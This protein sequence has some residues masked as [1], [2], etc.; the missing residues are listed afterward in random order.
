MTAAPPV[1]VVV[2]TRDRPAMLRAAVSAALA[3]EYP[4]AVEV[5]VVHDQS[6]PDTGL[7]GGDGHRRVRVVANTRTPGL[8]GARN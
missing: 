3:Q 2:P 5:V 7:A 6:P 8:A 1:S 4:G